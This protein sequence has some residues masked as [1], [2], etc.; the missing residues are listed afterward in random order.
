MP[1]KLIKAV[2]VLPPIVMSGI[3]QGGTPMTTMG[4]VVPDADAETR[5]LDWKARGAE[6]DRRTA[7]TMRGLVFVIIVAYAMWLFVQFA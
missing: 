6:S 5:W 4:A 3:I 1:L 2:A 7:K